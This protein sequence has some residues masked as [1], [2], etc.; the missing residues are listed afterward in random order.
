M[1]EA[2]FTRLLR[3]GRQIGVE[4]EYSTEEGGFTKFLFY[5]QES[6][7][8]HIESLERQGRDT[9]EEHAALNAVIAAGK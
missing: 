4:I 6:L 3:G 9:T 8:S 2:T 1:S 7:R 5:D